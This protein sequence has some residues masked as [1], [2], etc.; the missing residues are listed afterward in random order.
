[1]TEPEYRL[2]ERAAI[3]E[4]DGKLPRDEAEKLAREELK[5]AADGQGHSDT[6]VGG[7]GAVRARGGD[8][9]HGGGMGSGAARARTEND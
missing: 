4:F 8:R 7:C 6:K 3:I 5:G 1:M 9:D 2:A